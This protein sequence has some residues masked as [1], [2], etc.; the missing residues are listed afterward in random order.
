[1]KDIITKHKVLFGIIAGI[2]AL[3]LITLSVIIGIVITSKITCSH[4]N[5]YEIEILPYKA[6]TCQE[7]GLTLGKKCNYCGKILVEQQVIPKTDCRE[8]K[9]LPYKAPSCKETG[10]T[11]GKICTIC[12]KTVLDQQVIPK[13]S[14]NSNIT[15]HSVEPTCTATGLTQGKKCSVCGKITVEQTPLAKVNCEESKWIVD[16]DS[17]LKTDGYKHTECT[18]CGKT[19]QTQVIAAGSKGLTYIEQKDGTYLVKGSYYYSDPNVVIPRM[20]NEKNVVG[21][22]Y[23]AFLNN[24]NIETLSSPSTI[25]FIGS[26]AFYGCEKLKT[27]N[28]MEGLERIEGYAFNRCTSLESITLPSTLTFIGNEAFFNCTSLTTIIF[29]GTIEQWNAITF[30]SSWNGKVPATEVICSNGSVAL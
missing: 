3:M 26:Q 28:L 1:M 15:L 18:M 11:E 10:L 17:T 23:Y 7:E 29:K 9:I 14:C 6:A 21:I 24:K 22:Q 25:K 8:T 2:T 30:S 27:V 4:N 16:L 5:P 20:Y 13:E 12:G 19:M